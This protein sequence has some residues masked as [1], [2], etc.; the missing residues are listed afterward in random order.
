LFDPNRKGYL[1]REEVDQAF[2]QTGIMLT[3]DMLDEIFKKASSDGRTLKFSE[4]AYFMKTAE[5]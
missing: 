1:V 4:F 3:R 5:V 2:A